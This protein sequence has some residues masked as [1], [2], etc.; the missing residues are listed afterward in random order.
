MNTYNGHYK[1]FN[2]SLMRLRKIVYLF[3]RDQDNMSSSNYLVIQTPGD[4]I[5]HGASTSG[6]NIGSSTAATSQLN[7]PSSGNQPTPFGLTGGQGSNQLAGGK[8]SAVV[9][10]KFICFIDGTAEI[11]SIRSLPV[12]FRCFLQKHHRLVKN[13]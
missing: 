10:P 11:C 8:G 2:C 3:Y 12:K 5:S 6:G 7:S 4:P 9:S 1:I 13:H